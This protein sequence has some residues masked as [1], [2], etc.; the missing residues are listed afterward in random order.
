MPVFMPALRGL[1]DSKW[2]RALPG[3]YPFKRGPVGAL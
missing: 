1:G 2:N 3:P